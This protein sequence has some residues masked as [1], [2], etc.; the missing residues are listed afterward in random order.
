MTY[1]PSIDAWVIEANAD[2]IKEHGEQT[3]TFVTA[4]LRSHALPN[5]VVYSTN[6]VTGP[7]LLG[8]QDAIKLPGTATSDQVMQ[9]VLELERA[10]DVPVMVR[11][12]RLGPFAWLDPITRQPMRE[13]ACVDVASCELA[14]RGAAGGT[15]S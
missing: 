5:L 3:D 15:A 8:Q 13:Y 2:L 1:P 9:L 14:R 10:Y 12:V 4:W 7:R 6:H 11:R